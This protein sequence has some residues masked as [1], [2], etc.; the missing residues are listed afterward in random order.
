MKT[1]KRVCC[2]LLALLLPLAVPGRAWADRLEAGLAGKGSLAAMSTALDQTSYTDG[3]AYENPPPA[4]E[5]VKVGLEY[6]ENAPAEAV[7]INSGGRGFALGRYDESREFVKQAETEESRILLRRENGR[8]VLYA[9]PEEDRSPDA[10]A[11]SLFRAAGTS[12]ALLPLGGGPTEYGEE[13]YLG[14]FVCAALEPEGLTVINFVP[15]E[16][17]VKGVLPY[18]MGAGWPYE[19]LRAQAVCAR[20]YAVYNEN[21]YAEQGF[22]LTDDTYSQ[23][24]RG[25][26]QA[27]ETTDRAVDTTAGQLL[28]YKG[29]VCQIY[30]S[31]ADGGATE[32]GKNVFG[33]DRPYLAG[34]PDP[35]EGALNFPLK[36]WTLQY[37][38]EEVAAR[39]RE[40]GYA[41]ETVDT[42]RPVYSDTGNVTAICF[43]DEK[44]AQ[45]TIR[46]RRCVTVLG[47]N[48]P[49][50]K[51]E[52]GEDGFT[53]TGG[54]LGHG[55]G[56]SQWGAY[57]MAS[58]YGYDCE[59]I[60]RFYFTGAYIA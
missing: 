16:D 42:L 44:G 3:S 43:A 23:V 50:F 57:A 53:F 22:D 4:L 26:H 34:K 11:E 59:D 31:A 51:V 2:A 6:G 21:Q 24:Y 35:F 38:G 14:G 9:A 17:Y 8:P 46:G 36:S 56:M 20:T 33:V 12:L 37:S 5:T 48:S 40:A 58:L 10:G 52:Q 39:L 18:E 55:C 45:I 29:Q 60:L 27:T 54:G 32:D 30:Y 41:L 25:L 7:F 13:L 47:L 28:R 15:L 19:A 49:H 1:T